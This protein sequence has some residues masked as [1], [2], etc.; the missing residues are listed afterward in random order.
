M[1]HKVT[2]N[3]V[4]TP[5]GIG[6][7]LISTEEGSVNFNHD[8]AVYPGDWI[9]DKRTENHPDDIYHCPARSANFEDE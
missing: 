7:S 1:A 5:L 2:V 6:S 4:V 8:E 9:I 3:D